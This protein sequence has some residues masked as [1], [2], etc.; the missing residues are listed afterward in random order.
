ML[1]QPG[2]YELMFYGFDANRNVL[3]GQSIPYQVIEAT[4]F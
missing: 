1:Y 3:E 4:R 2:D